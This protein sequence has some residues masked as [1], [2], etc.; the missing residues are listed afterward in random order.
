[1]TAL[2]INLKFESKKEHVSEIERFIRTVKERIRSTRATIP[3]KLIPNLVIVHLFASY[4]FWI[5]AFPPSTHG[6]GLSDKKG[7]RQIILGNTVD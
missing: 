7:P 5:N 1:M 2:G 3:F 6:A 4:I